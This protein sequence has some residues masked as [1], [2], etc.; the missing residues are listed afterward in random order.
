MFHIELPPDPGPQWV[1]EIPISTE[2]EEL[3]LEIERYRGLLSN[4]VVRLESEE[5]FGIAEQKF[6]AGTIRQLLKNKV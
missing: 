4:I 3:K 2:I 5:W 1:Q 6:L